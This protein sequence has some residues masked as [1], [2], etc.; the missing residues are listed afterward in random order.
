MSTVATACRAKWQSSSHVRPLLCALLRELVQAAPGATT[1]LCRP[2]A[3]RAGKQQPQVEAPG[4]L[5]CSWWSSLT[6]RCW[7]SYIFAQTSWHSLT[8]ACLSKS[9]ETQSTRLMTTMEH[10]VAFLLKK[11]V[12]RGGLGITLQTSAKL[13]QKPGACPVA[14]RMPAS[15]VESVQITCEVTS[16]CICIRAFKG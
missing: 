7:I 5:N 3:R 4:P 14:A 11:D 1:F 13:L 15:S 8:G 6:R 2:T 12:V 16:Q 9:F 10:P